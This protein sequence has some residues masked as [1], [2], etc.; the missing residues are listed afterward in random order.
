MTIYMPHSA[1]PRQMV[2]CQLI[3][4]QIGSGRPK[5]RENRFSRQDDS[6]WK[7]GIGIP[8]AFF[9]EWSHR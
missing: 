2:D 4:G 5:G 6:L 8:P 7:S 9:M 1:L 3:I